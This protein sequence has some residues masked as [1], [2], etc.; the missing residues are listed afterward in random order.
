MEWIKILLSLDYFI[1]LSFYFENSCTK[2]VCFEAY[3]LIK[4]DSWLDVTFITAI[5]KKFVRNHFYQ[6]RRLAIFNSVI[7][8]VKISIFYVSI[9]T[10]TASFYFHFRSGF[11]G[12][13]LTASSWFGFGS[14]RSSTKGFDFLKQRNILYQVIYFHTTDY[15]LNEQYIRLK[16]Y[17]KG[18][19]WTN[20]CICG[21]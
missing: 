18:W 9:N 3:F 20:K 21:P 11:I 14:I 8:Y 15:K 1:F 16:S 13:T 12:V 5:D 10:I 6:V 7:I 17:T 19:T 4:F 2:K